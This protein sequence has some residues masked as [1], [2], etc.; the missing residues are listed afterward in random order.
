MN[1]KQVQAIWYDRRL[2]PAGLLTESGETIQ[3]IDPGSWN[4]REGPDFLNAILEIGADRRRLQGDVEIHLSPTDWNV[5]HHGEDAS[6]QHVIAHVVWHD[7]P[8]PASLPSGAISIWL[9]RGLENNA[10]FSADAIDV[11][12]YPYEIAGAACNR[13]CYLCFGRDPCAVE[14]LLRNCAEQRLRGKAARIGELLRSATDE[15]SR[16]QLFYEEVFTALGYGIDH[17]EFRR[18][19]HAV[20]LAY[21]MSEPENAYAALNSAASFVHTNRH[22]RP[23]NSPRYRIAAA[24]EMFVHGNIVQL[25]YAANFSPANCRK[26]VKLLADSGRI[27]RH[28]AAAILSNVILPWAMAERRVNAIPEWLPPEEISGQVRL[29]A[30]RLLGIDCNAAKTYAAND[31]K[32]Q[33]LLHIFKTYCNNSYPVCENCELNGSIEKRPEQQ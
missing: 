30:Y 1:E 28:R 14:W 4:L 15:L 6:Y 18:I 26:M 20:P 32:I 5:H 10:A 9:G 24:V 16:D 11:N 29:M 7:G 33:G 19:A 31:I 23:L 12:A 25:S 21:L 13:P 3:V 27:G 17:H 8:A 22:S 2:R